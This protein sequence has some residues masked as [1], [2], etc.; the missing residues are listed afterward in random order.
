MHMSIRRDAIEGVL[1]Q[2]GVIPIRNELVG[3]RAT[4]PDSCTSDSDYDFLVFVTSPDLYNA[5]RSLRAGLIWALPM[6]A[7]AS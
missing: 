1:R 7:I 6:L 2:A 5:K 3:S 4:C